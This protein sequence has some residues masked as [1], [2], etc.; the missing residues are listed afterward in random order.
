MQKNTYKESVHGR[1]KTPILITGWKTPKMKV[2]FSNV[3]K[4]FYYPNSPDTARFSLTT[5]VDPVEHKEFIE[6]LKKME[7]TEKCTT[8]FK[9]EMKKDEVGNLKPT[10]K[11]ILKFQT[12]E[13]I[14]LFKMMNGQP[15]PYETF[16]ELPRETEVEITFE[17]ARY[18]S[19]QTNQNGLSCRAI[20]ILIHSMPEV[21]YKSFDEPESESAPF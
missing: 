11:Y 16:K 1:S 4:P 14:P 7:A 18:T 2:I 17:V 3:V 12:K 5:V 20:Q 13:G 10:G 15:V 6:K 21:A 9:D 19:K 8:Q